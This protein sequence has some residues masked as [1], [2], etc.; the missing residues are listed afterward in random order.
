MMVDDD[1]QTLASSAVVRPQSGSAPITMASGVA[2]TSA[3]VLRGA[4]KAHKPTPF[5]LCEKIALFRAVAEV[6]QR[7][8]LVATQL[9]GRRRSSVHELYSTHELKAAAAQ[10]CRLAPGRERPYSAGQRASHSH[11]CD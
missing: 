4:T 3:G 8:E 9:P 7:W 1:R 10:Q 11:E 2:P 6:G 5:G